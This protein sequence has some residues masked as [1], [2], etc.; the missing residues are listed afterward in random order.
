[1]WLNTSFSAKTLGSVISNGSIGPQD[2]SKKLSLP[3]SISLL[4]GIHGAEPTQ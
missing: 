1:M 4:A 3:V 2:L